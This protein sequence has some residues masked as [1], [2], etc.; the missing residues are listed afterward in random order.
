[1]PEPKLSSIASTVARAF[2]ALIDGLA[3]PELGWSLWLFCGVSP[4]SQPAVVLNSKDL[5]GK[6]ELSN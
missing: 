1:M 2:A 4:V 6:S 3:S 5:G